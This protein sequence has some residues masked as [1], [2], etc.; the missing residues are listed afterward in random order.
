MIVFCHYQKLNLWQAKI[1][2]VPKMSALGTTKKN[3]F[4]GFLMVSGRVKTNKFSGRVKANKFYFD[5]LN[6]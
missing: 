6:L 1:N 4:I 3:M 5:M 2:G